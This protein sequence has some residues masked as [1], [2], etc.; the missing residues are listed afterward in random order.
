VIEFNPYSW[1]FHEDPLPIYRALRDEAPAYRNDELGFWALSRH[2]DVL[3]ALKDWETYSSSEGVALEAFDKEAW[4]LAFF[5][6]MDPPR[7][8]PRLGW[9]MSCTATRDRRSSPRPPSYRVASPWP[10]TTNSWRRDAK[11][12]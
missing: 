12:L 3:D 7:H 11:T 8:D 2:D 4:R 9:T 5:L 1:D 10:T 6:A